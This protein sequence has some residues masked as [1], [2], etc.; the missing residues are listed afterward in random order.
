MVESARTATLECESYATICRNLIQCAT[1][2]HGVDA[3]GCRQLLSQT[4]LAA[5][6]AATQGRSSIL[7]KA[8]GKACDEE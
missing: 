8:L 4:L 6:I 5:H 2:Q 1:E 7:R 3:R